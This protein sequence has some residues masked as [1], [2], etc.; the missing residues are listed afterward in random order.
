VKARAAV[1]LIRG[2]K[3]ALIERHR[4]GLHYFVFPGGK[5][6]AGETPAH[7]A[8]REAEEELG[9]KVHVH[10]MVAEVWYL[11]TPQ[12]YFLAEVTGGQFGQGMGSEMDS[13]PDSKKGIYRPTWMQLTSLLD[14]PVMPKLMAEFV[15][16]AIHAGWPAKSIVVTDQ[17]P[18][19][20][21]QV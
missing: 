3:I 1:I 12:Y 19:E 6:E 15:R 20:T 10:Q 4:Q 2:D 11:G 14:Q 13:A 9:L 7:A 16:K 5:V 21:A 8:S 17:T 18:D